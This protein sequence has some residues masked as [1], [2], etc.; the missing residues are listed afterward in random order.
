MCFIEKRNLYC[1][2]ST[3]GLL[4]KKIPGI[5]LLLFLV[6]LNMYAGVTG[7]VQGVAKDKKT[8]ETLYGVNVTIMG[9]TL[10]AATDLKG[11]YFILQVPPGVYSVKF[12]MVGYRDVIITDV[13]VM[14]E[15][16]AR[17]D[18]ELEEVTVGV[19]GEVVVKAKR[20]VIQKD[21]TTSIQFLG[22]EEMT[23]LPVI[24]A[25][26]G[27]FVQAGVFM[28]P[29]PVVGG[30]GSA[31]R[32]EQRYS[33]RGGSQQEVR[34]YYDGVRAASLV[35]GRADWGGSFT[36]LNL[37]SIQE[38]QVMTG[39]FT[40]EYGDAQSGIVNVITKEGN[41]QIHAS[42]EGIYG[43]AGQHHFGS[44]LYDRT[45]QK[46]FLDHTLPD[47]SL[48]PKWW[49]PFRQNQI[50]DYTKIPDYTINT[51]LNG[52]LFNINDSPLRFFI[53]SSIKQTA[54]SLPHP[55]DS[56][57]MEN[58]FLNLS[59]QG[60][61]MKFRI[62]GMFNHDAYSTLQENGDFTNQAKYNRGWG[63]L[64]DTYSKSLSLL[65]THILSKDLFYELKLGSYFIDFK[66]KPS[67]FTYLGKSKN[68]T[69]F[70]FMR[71]DGFEDEPF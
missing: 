18:A 27:L 47:G 46:E 51:S 50:Y 66:E 14:S 6:A 36:N 63:S 58:V 56:R 53:S 2:L 67:E 40:A 3:T 62:N 49:T 43:F 35:N 8:G 39:G 26:E 7:K 44:Y 11:E 55:R 45:S 20:P 10:G 4:L 34:W 16:T 59:L 60:K 61:D 29:I 48:D 28:D 15:L 65:Y 38:V 24:D 33:I 1:R 32:G 31:G 17:V 64:I 9:K 42:V 23:R 37:N 41:D 68:P 21:V 13:K 5:F 54:Y 30:L 12:S 57:N 71:Y 22:A 69:V 25:K 19:S 70:G 52:P